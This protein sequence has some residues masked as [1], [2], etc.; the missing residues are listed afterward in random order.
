M[1]CTR[2]N[3]VCFSPVDP[4]LTEN[5]EFSEVNDYV[6]KVMKE[7]FISKHPFIDISDVYFSCYFVEI[8]H[9]E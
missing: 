8:A 9:D 7:D 4:S 3:F 5:Y 2:L 1:K 6:V